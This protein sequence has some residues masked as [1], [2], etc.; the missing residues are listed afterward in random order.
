LPRWYISL[1]VR[2]PLVQVRALDGDYPFY[3]S[4]ETTPISAGR[5]FRGGRQALVDKTL[6]CNMG[7]S[8]GSIK[9]G[10]CT[11]AIA[12]ILNKA[13][14][15]N[16]IST[17]V[18]PPVYIPSNTWRRP[19]YW[20]EAAGSNTSSNYQYDPG[21]DMEKFAGTIRPRLEK[22]TSTKRRSNPGRRG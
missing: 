8:R 15:R 14:G 17:T 2:V 11:F 3:G 20:K 12:G 9:I 13:P 6:C 19:G 1:K 21:V 5:S 18:A 4:L 22:S 10:E 16:E 7:T